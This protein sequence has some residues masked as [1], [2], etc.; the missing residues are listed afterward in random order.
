MLIF[1]ELLVFLLTY[2][3]PKGKFEAI[4]Y[5]SDKDIFIIKRL[6]GTE[7]VNARE[8][9]LNYYKIDIPIR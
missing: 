7:Q 1:I 2:I 3:I 6:N 5:D 9:I 4:E 8:A